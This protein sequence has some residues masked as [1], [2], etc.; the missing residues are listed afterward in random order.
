MAF[1]GFFEPQNEPLEIREVAIVSAQEFDA[2]FAPEIA[3]ERAE[4]IVELP[5]IEPEEQAP[6][7]PSV[8]EASAPTPEVPAV[9]QSAAPDSVPDNDNLYVAPEPKPLD[10]PPEIQLPMEQ[11]AILAPQTQQPPKP[12]SVAK[13]A[14]EPVQAPE[15]EIPIA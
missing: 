15:P 12:K 11:V 1:G 4:D 10:M 3:P 2:L 5:S 13:I 14:P 8:A 9:V 7:F 6:A